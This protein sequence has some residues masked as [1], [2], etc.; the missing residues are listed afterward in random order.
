MPAARH[1]PRRSG[2]GGRPRPGAAQPPDGMFLARGRHG[3]AD[4]RSDS[5]PGWRNGCQITKT[6]S[7][8]PCDDPCPLLLTKPSMAVQEGLHRLVSAVPARIMGTGRSAPG[9]SR[10]VPSRGPRGTARAVANHCSEYEQE[11]R[12]SRRSWRKASASPPAGRGASTANG[13]AGSSWPGARARS[14][15]ASGP[16]DCWWPA[17][18]AGRIALRVGQAKQAEAGRPVLAASARTSGGTPSS[19]SLA[20]RKSVAVQAS[21][22][23]TQFR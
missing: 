18:G 16:F 14:G 19:H 2:Q 6:L 23:V 5:A 4:S 10:H 11:T 3:A 21:S 1:R 12:F 15:G 22:M 9:S 17:G 7:T 8:H 13:P 20:R